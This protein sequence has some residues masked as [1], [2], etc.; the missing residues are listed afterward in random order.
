MRIDKQKVAESFHRQA[1][2]YDR[3]ATVQARITKELLAMVRN[4]SVHAPT[5]ILDVGCGTGRLLAELHYQYPDAMLYGV[6]IAENMVAQTVKR[7]GDKIDAIVGDAEQLD[8]PDCSFDLI[9]SSSTLQWLDTIDRFLDEAHRVLQYGGLLC[10]A[11]FGGS[12]LCEVQRCYRDVIARRCG[13]NDA[14]LERLHRFI[15]LNEVERALENNPFE[16][17]VLIS[18][19]EVEYYDNLKELLRSIQHVGAGS[20]PHVALPSRG[21]LGWRGLLQEMSEQYQEQYEE[22]GKIPANYEVFYLI[23]RK[24]NRER[25]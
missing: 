11:F 19:K 21:G 18:A 8:F 13:D 3:H 25:Q 7:L 14:R 4:Y 23:A 9:V 16:Q 20:T 2:E 12:T 6:D 1:F 10:A 17:V 24:I 5:R 22:D 15:S